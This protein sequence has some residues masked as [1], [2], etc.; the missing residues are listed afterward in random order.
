MLGPDAARGRLKSVRGARGRRR[1]AGNVGD[2]HR[3]DAARPDPSTD[4]DVAL[5]YRGAAVISPRGAV[6]KAGAPYVFRYSRFFAP[7][8]LDGPL[9]RVH[10]RRGSGASS[11]RRST[12]LLRGAPLK[13]VKADRLD[14]MSGGAI[15]EGVPRDRFAFV[16]RRDAS[17]CRRGTTPCR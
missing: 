5:E 12:Q 2:D 8:Q 7:A 13:T 16:G 6:T 9:L 4:Y 1:A 10:R 11:R 14:Y 15:E 3:R 17:I